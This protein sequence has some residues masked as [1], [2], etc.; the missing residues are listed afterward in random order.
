M[1]AVQDVR[2]PEH[3]TPPWGSQEHSHTHNSTAVAHAC[4]AREPLEQRAEG[5]QLDLHVADTSSPWV[6]GAGEDGVAALHVATSD[7]V[8]YQQRVRCL[9]PS[10]LP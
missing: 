7:V 5:K 3:I 9:P 1:P 10:N 4:V 2:C 8:L 6:G